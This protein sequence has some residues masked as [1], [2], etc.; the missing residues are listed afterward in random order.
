MQGR[1]VLAVLAALAAPGLAQA[2][3]FGGIGRLNGTDRHGLD[4]CDS[5]LVLLFDG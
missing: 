2:Q 4:L 5:M 3:P 1:F